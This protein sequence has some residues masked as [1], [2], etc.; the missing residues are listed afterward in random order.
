MKKFICLGLVAMLALSCYRQPRTQDHDEDYL[1]Y[2]TPAEAIDFKAFQ[3]YHVP[4]SLLVAGIEK[5]PYYV[6]DKDALSIIETFK[7]EME[8]CGYTYVA[9]RSQADL[10]L[11]LTYI[12]YTQYY[13]EYYDPYWWWYGPG[14]WSPSYW[15]D[16]YGFYYPSA[17]MYTTSTNM[18]IS[19]L[20][21][22]TAVQGENQRLPVVWN[23]IMS[24]PTGSSLKQDLNRLTESI[25]QAFA[26]SP[27]LKR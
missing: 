16:W 10:G 2:T 19:N 18:M 21:D 20:L 22:L 14:Y 25:H 15:G 5:D 1:V 27:Y 4:D 6:S 26:Q 23:A 12:V 11:Q 13:V 9:D 3:T 24:G 7:G 8:N 17:M